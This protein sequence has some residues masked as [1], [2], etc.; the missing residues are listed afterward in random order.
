MTCRAIRVQDQ[1]TCGSC[2][3][4][5]DVG[6]PDR[7]VC[8]LEEIHLGSNERYDG[9]IFGTPAYALDEDFD[10]DDLPLSLITG[11]S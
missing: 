4:Q 8:G 10:Q 1:M 2:G 6:D 9:K 3:L 5:W 7:P 11:L